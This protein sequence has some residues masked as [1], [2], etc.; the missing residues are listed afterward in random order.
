MNFSYWNLKS[1]I[2]PVQ[3]YNNQHSV[4]CV[5]EISLIMSLTIY[6]LIFFGILWNV[7]MYHIALFLK[8]SDILTLPYSK[9][10]EISG[11]RSVIVCKCKCQNLC[12]MYVIIL[13][14]DLHTD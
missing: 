1:F 11:I 2:L 9:Q 12:I 6:L 3:Q 5:F 7:F 14:K 8:I 10:Q 13:L 4:L